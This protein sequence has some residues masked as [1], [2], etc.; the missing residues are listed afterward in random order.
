MQFAQAKTPPSAPLHGERDEEH[1]FGVQIPFR[2]W[3]LDADTF[4]TRINN[5]LDHSNIGDSSIYY[6][7]TVDGALIRAWELTL[8]SPAALAHRARPTSPTPTRSPSSAAAIT[9]GL[10]C[11]PIASPDCDAGFDYSPSITTSATP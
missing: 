7:V 6:P 1:Q 3:L 11:S 2:G 5:F 4:K 10:I 8:R 9:G